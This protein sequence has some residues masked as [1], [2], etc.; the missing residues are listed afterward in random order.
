MRLFT[1]AAAG[2]L[3]TALASADHDHGKAAPQ[4]KPAGKPATN[5]CTSCIERRATLD[6]A[7]FSDTK[8]YEPDVKP[9]YEVARK[10]PALLDRLHCFCECQESP[11][12]KHKT[13]L[14]CFTD[15][16]AAGCGICIKEALLA[17]QLK[18][19]GVSDP[20]IETLVEQMFKTDGH[21][22]THDHGRS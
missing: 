1:L 12:F 3:V 13:L 14:T 20:E 15:S 8:I 5:S 17:A 6:P 18:E 10:Y 19:K 4:K 9:A 11:N 21:R 7:L 2:L 22:D 16:H